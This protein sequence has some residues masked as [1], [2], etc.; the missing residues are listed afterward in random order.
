MVNIPQ[1]FVQ[2]SK[3]LKDERWTHQSRFSIGKDRFNHETLSLSFVHA[4]YT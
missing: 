3:Q 4:E 2:Q 1:D